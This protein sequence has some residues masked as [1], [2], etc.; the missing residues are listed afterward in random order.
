M[1]IFA[2]IIIIYTFLGGFNAVCWTDFFQ[3]LL[4]IVALVAVPIM[5]CIR[6]GLDTSALDTVYEFDGTTYAFVGNAFK[7]DWRDIISGLGW[8]LGY[9]GMPPHSGALYVD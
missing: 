7:A 1:L 6:G 8:G 5:V 4:M 3:G 2:L 9:F